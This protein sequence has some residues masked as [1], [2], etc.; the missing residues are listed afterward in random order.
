M[1]RP[2]TFLAWTFGLTWLLEA[3]FVARERGWITVAPQVAMAPLALAAVMPTLVAIALTFRDGGRRGA[4]QLLGWRPFSAMTFAWLGLGL[5][6]PA[7]LHGLATLPL[8]AGLV[9][10]PPTTAEHV[11]IAIL[12]PLGE[13]Y[14]WRGLL[15]PAWSRRWGPATAALAVG[16]VWALWHAPTWLLPGVPGWQPIQAIVFVTAL[17]V[18]FAALHFRARGNLLVAIGAHLGLHLD[19]VS[20]S[21]DPPALWATTTL[22]AFAAMALL[23]RQP[24]LGADPAA[25]PT[26]TD[27]IA[28][29]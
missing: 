28:R 21:G 17:S 20:R 22:T 12:A 4:A 5:I 2:G 25:Q 16:L 19:N 15:L 23:R 24:S 1:P 26:P 29:R 8:G 13:E 7:A 3:P 11:G 10:Y 18:I 27:P 9:L 14:G 6:L